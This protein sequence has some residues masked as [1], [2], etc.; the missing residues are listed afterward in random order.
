MCSSCSSSYTHEDIDEFNFYLCPI[1][2]KAEKNQP[3]SGVLSIEYDYENISNS[4]SCT[5]FLSN[6]SGKFWLYP[7]LWPI[8]FNKIDLNT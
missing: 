7:Y 8:D 3:L 1:C 5:E 4:V 2:G 6:D